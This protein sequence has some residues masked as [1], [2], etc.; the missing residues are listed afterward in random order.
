MER[1]EN[2]GV[3]EIMVARLGRDRVGVKNLNKHLSTR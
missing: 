3:D 2:P 1:V